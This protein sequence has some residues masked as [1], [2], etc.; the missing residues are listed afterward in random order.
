M[1]SL[2]FCSAFLSLSFFSGPPFWIAHHPCLQLRCASAAVFHNSTDEH[3]GTSCDTHCAFSGWL[4]IKGR[5]SDRFCGYLSDKI[6]DLLAVK[7]LQIAYFFQA[8]PSSLLQSC[9]WLLRCLYSSEVVGKQ[10]F[11]VTI[12]KDKQGR[13]RHEAWEIKHTI[14]ENT[15]PVTKKLGGKYL[16]K[17]SFLLF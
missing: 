13:E 6:W 5:G 9:E 4:E 15:P 11:F 14:G 16:S 2:R 3:E 7:P 17:V 10:R 12:Q 1:P 8:V